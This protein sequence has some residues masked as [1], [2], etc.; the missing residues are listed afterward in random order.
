MFNTDLSDTLLKYSFLMSY[1]EHF[2]IVLKMIT[3]EQVKEYKRLYKAS[4]GALL[5]GDDVAVVN[6]PNTSWFN[7]LSHHR[8]MAKCGIK[9][10]PADNKLAPC[11]DKLKPLCDLTFIGNTT[12]KATFEF[13]PGRIYWS[14]PNEKSLLKPLTFYKPGLDKLES[15]IV[16]CNDTVR[17]T[18]PSYGKQGFEDFKKQVVDA[19]LAVGIVLN[20]WTWDEC[21][22]KMRPEADMN[23]GHLDYTDEDHAEIYAL[24]AKSH[25]VGRPHE[26]V[27]SEIGIPQMDVDTEVTQ[28]LSLETPGPVS[29]IGITSGHKGPAPRKTFLITDLCKR[30][31]PLITTVTERILA[32]GVTN[33]ELITT[34]RGY[35]AYFSELYRVWAGGI[36]IDIFTP[37]TRLTLVSSNENSQTHLNPLFPVNEFGNYQRIPT[38]GYFPAAVRGLGTGFMN[39]IVPYTTE[40]NFSLLPHFPPNTPFATGEFY[41]TAT[42]S[43]RSFVDPPAANSVF[44]GQ[45]LV[46]GS[47]SIRLGMLYRVPLL[48]VVGS[49]FNHVDGN[50]ALVPQFV[51]LENAGVLGGST[52]PWPLSTL[53]RTPNVLSY[54]PGPVVTTPLTGT[55]YH[56]ATQLDFASSYLTDEEL[57]AVGVQIAPGQNRSYT[58]GTLTYLTDLS[59]SAIIGVSPFRIVINEVYNEKSELR[60]FAATANP[61][62]LI[63]FTDPSGKAYAVANDFS[64]DPTVLAKDSV[65]V[66]LGLQSGT[67]A[68]PDF[69]LAM[70]AEFMPLTVVPTPVPEH[71]PYSYAPFTSDGLSFFITPVAD[72]WHECKAIP[73]MESQGVSIDPYAKEEKSVTVTT[74]PSGLQDME[75]TFVD[76]AKRPQ[77]IKRFKWRTND[78]IGEQLIQ[79]NFPTDLLVSNTI[80]APFNTFR[81]ASWT[82][83]EITATIT[84]NPFQSGCLCMYAVP[85][86]DPS[87]VARTH[88]LSLT[89]Q[90]T[91]PNFVLFQ[92]GSN[93]SVSLSIPW[94]YPTVAWDSDRVEIDPLVALFQISVFSPLKI[95]PDAP[96][97]FVDITLSCSIQGAA[98]SV[99]RVHADKPAFDV[100]ATRKR[101]ANIKSARFAVRDIKDKTVHIHARA[102]M[103][104]SVMSSLASSAID[105]GTQA[106]GNGLKGLMNDKPNDYA[107][108]PVSRFVGEPNLAPFEG[109]TYAQPLDE[110]L[111]SRYEA[112]SPPS[113]QGELDFGSL[114]ERYSYGGRFTVNTSNLHEDLVFQEEL[115][116][117]SEVTSQ[118]L[119]ATF[120]PTL[121]CYLSLASTFWSC[122]SITYRFTMVGAN[123]HAVRLAFMTNYGEF[124]VPKDETYSQF[125]QFCE[126][127]K[128]EPTAEIQ[129]P[130]RS[131]RDFL[132]VSKGYNIDRARYAFGSLYGR[133]V[134]SLQTTELLPESVE[135]LVFVSYKGMK[136]TDFSTGPLDFEPIR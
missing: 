59:K 52:M 118:S 65:L 113:T 83:V 11:S 21:I 92:A 43:A 108:P 62:G 98:F 101:V 85:M 86:T 121:Q 122:E 79:L 81:Y 72:D 123:G 42:L 102:Q 26:Q 104:K 132:R 8:Q 24:A 71:P 22:D 39:A 128:A 116:P 88:A 127:T 44:E 74:T 9:I 105:F 99:P 64:V 131:P 69:A 47:D 77:V 58:F 89:S 60:G 61:T 80:A 125:V 5:Y 119:G 133:V 111:G 49:V 20:T 4:V 51:R 6:T 126:F 87:E 50:A 136:L 70:T 97:N 16:C 124:E 90:T 53:L 114:C 78:S 29:E 31:G 100:S 135:F 107:N 134:G 36:K 112:K 73:Q 76:L 82:M 37:G 55:V 67:I 130:W 25:L 91:V 1:C 33:V 95:G 75:Q 40:Y 54:V 46:S 30:P 84:S 129:V 120:Q 109:L 110:S 115:S 32:Q 117:T 94:V 19:C 2:G 66:K 15:F 27:P 96:I 56:E 38:N 41:A 106:L 57:R 34:N 93:T 14:K 23:A 17:R 68:I 10:T 13:A 103:F 12:V 63:E 35:L 18:F 7:Q 28:L 3:R 48:T 45:M